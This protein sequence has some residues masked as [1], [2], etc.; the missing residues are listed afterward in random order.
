MQNNVASIECVSDGLLMLRGD[1]NAVTAVELQARG[2]ALIAAQSASE[3]LINLEHVGQSTSVGVALLTVWL[4]F[5]KMNNKK[6]CYQHMPSSML[7]IVQL[8]GL[9]ELLANP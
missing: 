7:A 2:Q 6:I 1:L 4:R 9:N 3:C 8:S 5:A